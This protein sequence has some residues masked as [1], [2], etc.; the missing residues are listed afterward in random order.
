MTHPSV[1]SE[2]PRTNAGTSRR[3]A[4]SSR[5]WYEVPTL[6]F[7]SKNSIPRSRRS[8]YER[9]PIFHRWIADD[10]AM[11]GRWKLILLKGAYL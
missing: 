10:Y 1:F 5:A 7:H 8:T 9:W 11:L 2:I 6:C 3:N 4:D